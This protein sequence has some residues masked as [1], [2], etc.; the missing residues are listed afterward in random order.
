MCSWFNSQGSWRPSGARGRFRVGWGTLGSLWSCW[1]TWLCRW[2]TCKP[3]GGRA[4]G[5]LESSPRSFRSHWKTRRKIIYCRHCR[6][7]FS[8]ISKKLKAWQKKTQGLFCVTKLN[9]SEAISDFTKKTQEISYPNYCFS[10]GITPFRS[11]LFTNFWYLGK[12]VWFLMVF[13]SIH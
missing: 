9:L 10:W 8:A 6:L 1:C 12:E 2:S 3:S 4:K 13:C 5:S 7:F 11:F